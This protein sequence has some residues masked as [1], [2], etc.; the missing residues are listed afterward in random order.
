MPLANGQIFAGYRIL[1]RLGAGA[2][3]EVYLA[4]HPRLPRQDA[5]KVLAP[6]V[7]ADADYRARFAREADLA[8]TLWHPNIVGVHDRGEQ[9]GQLWI[10]MDFVDGIDAARLLADRYPAGMPIEEVAR[11]VTAVASALD[12]A[13]R[14]GMLHRDV[15]PAN[16]MLTQLDDEGEQRILLTDFGIARNVNDISGLTKTNMTVGTVAYCA[17]EQLLGE[18]VDGRADQYSL[19]ATAYHLLTGSQLFPNSNPAVVISHHLNVPPAALADSRPEFAK[20][21][22]VLAMGLAKRPED[23]FKRCSDFAHALNQQTN[24]VGIPTPSAPTAP[25]VVRRDVPVV[26][27]R[28]PHDDSVDRNGR[29][30]ASPQPTPPI[31]TRGGGISRRTIALIVGAIAFVAVIAAAVGIPAMVRHPAGMGS[32]SNTV[33]VTSGDAVQ[34]GADRDAAAQVAKEYALK[35]LTYSFEDPD[36]FF[37]SV[38]DGVCQ[39]LKDKYVN[40]TDELKRIMLQAQ[41]TSTGEVLA[42]DPVAQPGGRAYEVVVSAH[43]TTRNRQNPTPKVSIILLQVTVNKVGNAWQVCDIGPK[44]GAH[45]PPP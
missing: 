45:D 35:S 34:A 4:Q 13:H 39:Q 10:T 25:A 8:S 7:S 32:S 31:P 3:G 29:K 18:D 19:A 43:Q 16:I 12:Y 38:E 23:R 20:L 22:P 15:K 5:L 2:M 6:D 30:A 14:Q 11:I 33:P 1:R 42:T 9:D 21:D 28:R 36:A 26:D 41:V 27:A 24:S 40:A 17:P 37:R 44:T